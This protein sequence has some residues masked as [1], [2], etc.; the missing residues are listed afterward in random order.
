MTSLSARR[1]AVVPFSLALAATTVVA[2]GTSSYAAPRAHHPAT[3]PTTSLSVVSQAP[4]S[5]DAWA[6]GRWSTTKTQGTIVSHR[7][8][9]H[10]TDSTVKLPVNGQLVGLAAGSAKT[11]WVTG[12]VYTGTTQNPLIYKTSG[13]RLVKAKA[14]FA[15]GSLS[16]IAASSTKNAW[17]MG[18]KV[19]GTTDVAVLEHWNGKR[20]SAP[21]LPKGFGVS[22]ISTSGPANAWALGSNAKGTAVARWTG[23]KWLLSSYHSPTGRYATAIATASKTSTFVTGYEYVGAHPVDKNFS[24]H[25]NGRKWKI[26][27]TPSKSSSTLNAVTAVGSTAWATGVDQTKGVPFIMHFSG[28]A[29]H[30]Q[31]TP[32]PGFSSQLSSV[33]ASSP[34]RATAVGSYATTKIPCGPSRGLNLVYNGHS[35]SNGSSPPAKFRGLLSRVAGQG[36]PLGC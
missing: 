27:K 6:L 23:R 31:S 29:W 33:S 22:S 19:V 3:A 17:V 10:W 5:S 16:A 35:W 1:L 14:P 12:Y 30:F 9:G 25:F 8:N 7:H 15:H 13:R 11:A 26:L 32:S 20:W 28:G 34:S 2:A 24:A 36:P 21:T 18:T 4:G